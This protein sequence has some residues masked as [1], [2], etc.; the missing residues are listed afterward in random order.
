MFQCERQ[1]VLNELMR[2]DFRK[3]VL[4]LLQT[5]SLE[6]NTDLLMVGGALVSEVCT[7]ESVSLFEQHNISS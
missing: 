7:A 4:F 1:E 6:L 5:L 3:L 2:I